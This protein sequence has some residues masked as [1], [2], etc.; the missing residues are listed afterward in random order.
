MLTGVDAWSSLAPKQE[1]GGSPSD[2]GSLLEETMR[3]RLLAFMTLG[4]LVVG[5][6]ALAG[7][8]ASQN[9]SAGG[10][11]ASTGNSSSSASISTGGGGSVGVV[12]GA[13]TGGSSA[14]GST[15]SSSGG[16]SG[17]SSS[18]GGGSSA[19]TT[20]AA[21]EGPNAAQDGVVSQLDLPAMGTVEDAV[22]ASGVRSNVII[23]G[24]AAIF[25]VGLF[26]LYRKLPRARAAA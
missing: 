11:S 3:L 1:S 26:I 17:S 12:Q 10:S 16:G 22:S 18:G 24:L 8:S 19:A 2:L 13:V 6:P 21:D 14:G 7:S 15:S 20:G 5:G 9:T 4:I 25:A 23:L